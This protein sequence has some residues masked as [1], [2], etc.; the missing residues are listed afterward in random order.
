MLA[1]DLAGTTAQTLID[2]TEAASAAALLETAQTAADNAQSALETAQTAVDNAQSALETAQTAADGLGL[3]GEEIT[4][5]SENL[6]PARS[7]VDNAQSALETAQT[8]ADQAAAALIVEQ[9]AVLAEGLVES[10]P[11]TEVML[12]EIRTYQNLANGR[13]SRNSSK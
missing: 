8:A 1:E 7:A 10:L 6:L 13:Q 12:A 11:V 2:L 3:I 4:G 5:L 9:N